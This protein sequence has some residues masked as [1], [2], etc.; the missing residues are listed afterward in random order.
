MR[1]AIVSNISAGIGLARDYELLNEFLQSLGHSVMGVQ[2]DAADH[3]M[4]PDP[5][6]DHYDLVI[7]M[8]VAPR[9]LMGLSDRRWIFLNPDWCKPE[10]IQTVDKSFQKIF[11]K[12]RE[13]ERIFS[14]LFPG[15]VHFVGFLARDQYDP[16]ITRRPWFLHVGGNSS[17]RG[18]QTVLDA[19]RWKKNGKTLDSPLHLI[20]STVKDEDLPPKVYLF[21]HVD[22]DVLKFYQNT[23]M[24][25]IYPSGTEGWGHAI[26]EALGVGAQLIT[27]GRPP[28]S[29]IEGA[30]FINSERSTKYNL[31][32]VWEVSALDIIEAVECVSRMSKDD[33]VSDLY[34]QKFLE[35]NEQF[36][37]LFAA[38]L[39][40]PVTVITQAMPLL[41]AKGQKSIAFLG[42]FDA[43]ESTENQVLWALTE[44]LDMHVVKLQENTVRL[45]EVR[46]AALYADAFLWVKTPNW[47]HVRDADM[48][49]LLVELG[50]KGIPSISMHLDKF[51]GLPERENLVG[52]DP[53]WLTQHVWTADGSPQAAG[54]FMA[55]KVNHHWM[56]PAVSEVYCHPGT[57]RDEYRCDVL[58]VGAR[59]YHP[60][61]P[62]RPMLVD[63]LQREYGDSFHHVT[64]IRGHRLNDVYAS[65][66]VV[67]GDCIF[68]GTQ[69]YWSDRVPETVGRYGNLLHPLIDG[70]DIPCWLYEPQ[71]LGKLAD[72]IEV[73]LEKMSPEMLRLPTIKAA[74]Y[75]KKHHTWT[76]RMQ[77]ILAGL[78]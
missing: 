37:K 7:Y 4:L 69:N 56:R 3:G 77:E 49:H 22:E 8:E 75:V 46:E 19:W 73:M 21:D 41:R 35:D 65:A 15:R 71:N 36:K 47:L 23:C 33:I 2:F 58:F 54:F 42:N 14:E 50:Q 62:F 53:F 68:A 57:P 24:F 13:G 25:H 17:L 40:P 11:A 44:R 6:V 16:A 30:Y 1:V 74:E 55:R 29:E 76:V 61:Y 12:T 10:V 78:L 28:M 70:L 43:P 63:F 67:V 60:E 39:E 52:V 34:R 32:D 18:T 20:S 51:F 72:M 9:N 59:D 66:K 26:H 38:H 31:A 48:M 45:P 27:T 5:A 64:T